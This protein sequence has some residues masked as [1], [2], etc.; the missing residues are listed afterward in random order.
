M[1]HAVLHAQLFL[2]LASVTRKRGD[3]GLSGHARF[4]THVRLFELL[5]LGLGIHRRLGGYF[6]LG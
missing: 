4:R 2:I 6:L 3:H 1:L 5:G